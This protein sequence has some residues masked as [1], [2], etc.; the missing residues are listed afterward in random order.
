MIP[1]ERIFSFSEISALGPLPLLVPIGL[2]G[3]AAL[4]AWTKR[5]IIVF[6]LGV[7]LMGYSF[8]TGFSIGNA[9]MPAGIALV[10]AAGVGFALPKPVGVDDSK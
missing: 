6:V 10:V 2:T 9:Y 7:V 5:P 4:A 3:V 1:D 8:I